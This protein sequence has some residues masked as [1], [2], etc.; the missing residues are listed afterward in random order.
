MAK[1]VTFLYAAVWAGYVVF[2]LLMFPTW[3]LSTA[4]PMFL[5][6]GIGAWLYGTRKGLGIVCG[7][8]VYHIYLLSF[9][10]ADQLELYQTKLTSPM[11]GILIVFAVGLLR[12]NYEAIRELNRVLDRK[13]SDR[14][15]RLSALTDELLRDSE[16]L[17]IAHGEKL[18]DGIGQLLTG[19]QLLGSSLCEQLLAE[20]DPLAAQTH[21][22]RNKTAAV[23]LQIRQISRLLFP[24]RI[25]QVGLTPALREFASCISELRKIKLEICE[26][27]MP[28]RAPDSIALDLYRICQDTVMHAVD[29]L[30]ADQLSIRL[31]DTET[32]CLVHVTHNG[33]TEVS[34]EAAPL[35]G[36]R[37]ARIDGTAERS[38]SA[39]GKSITE[40]RCLYRP[41]CTEGISG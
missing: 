22:L 16:R 21:L 10:Y 34:N 24:V 2:S 38:R 27:R 30:Q 17:K 6:I 35:I 1:K 31:T 15:E 3:N 9:L 41:R 14:T 37:L 33:T 29:R 18:H 12:K 7:S 26:P 25:S 23:H 32:A 5:L 13:V 4:I 28:I 36:Y 19:V 20:T 11:L 40:Y 39:D 8:I